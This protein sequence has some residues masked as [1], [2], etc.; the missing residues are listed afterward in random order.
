MIVI[1]ADPHKSKHTLVAVSAATGELLA[2][3]TV[4]AR[5][6]GYRRLIDWARGLGAERVFAIED[7]RHVSGSLERFLIA[8]GER[9]VRVA[10]KHMAGAR[11]SVRECGKSDPI[12]AL[13]VARAA[14]G[15]GIESLPSAFLDPEAMEIK[16]LAD[17]RD[18]LV[19][20]RTRIQNRL[21]WHLHDLWPE[22]EV[23][24]G[25][26]GRAKWLD[27]LARRLARA[28]QT[29][30]VGVC[31]E[32]VRR[33]RELTRRVDE[34][35]RELARRVAAK[36][37]AL[38]EIPGCGTLSAARLIA[39]TAGIERFASE[40]K[41]ARL[42]GLAPIPACS[43]NANRHRLDRGGNRQLNRA[44]HRIAHSQAKSYEPARVYVARKEAEGK[45]R[46]E[47]LRCLKRQ[48]VRAILGALRAPGDEHSPSIKK[49]MEIA[50]FSR[51]A[52]PLALT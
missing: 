18:D 50:A 52:P 9:V 20:E 2:E 3:L 4:V 13:A 25:G 8:R 38:A 33:L 43:G 44:V 26:L 37:P 19:A 7:C 42:A 35:E 29:V 11:R 47:A 27:R 6:A 5:E 21:R 32:Q 49:E 34:L 22:L 24:S 14:L 1:G 40:A 51:S 10:P 23:P 46:K 36:N 41:F 48:L 15:E 39:E 45:G 12:D 28:E 17:H 31:R 16:L 30:K